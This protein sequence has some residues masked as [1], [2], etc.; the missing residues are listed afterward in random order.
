MRLIILLGLALVLLSFNALAVQVCFQ[1]ASHN[2]VSCSGFAGACNNNNCDGR[3]GTDC[4]DCPSG[5]YC[6]LNGQCYQF[7]DIPQDVDGVDE[8]YAVCS[9]GFWYDADSCMDELSLYCIWPSN[10][11]N[12]GWGAAEAVEPGVGEY[13]AND[14]LT[15][16]IQCCGDDANE[17]FVSVDCNGNSILQ[18]SGYGYDYGK[19][20][21]DERPFFDGTNCVA[22]CGSGDNACTDHTETDS[23]S[24]QAYCETLS[25]NYAC[26]G[27]QNCCAGGSGTFLSGGVFETGFGDCCG[28]DT[29]EFTTTKNSGASCPACCDNSTDCCVDG[30]CVSSGSQSNGNCCFDSGLADCSAGTQSCYDDGYIQDTEICLIDEDCQASGYT[31]PTLINCGALDDYIYSDN[32]ISDGYTDGS[33]CTPSCSGN[34][35]CV[36]DTYVCDS[37]NSDGFAQCDNVTL[38]SGT[39]TFYCFKNYLPQ[40]WFI[41]LSNNPPLENSSGNSYF[42]CNDTYDNDCDGYIDYLDDDCDYRELGSV[43]FCPGEFAYCEPKGRQTPLTGDGICPNDFGLDCDSLGY[44]DVDC[45]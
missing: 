1:N 36:Q 39:K 10:T 31:A 8:H 16:N 24:N 3:I 5:S 25:G 35:C 12:L 29:F 18:D 23:D 26:N 9:A 4:G 41:S 32:N 42:S 34:G 22:S 11:H 17:T 15:N 19:C 14:Y 45:P 40:G 33:S 2:G 20:C 21:P 28:D 7:P 37:D 30:S 43:E 6:W 27:A 13:I 38:E 44:P